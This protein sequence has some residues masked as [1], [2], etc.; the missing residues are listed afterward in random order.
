VHCG[1][2]GRDELLYPAPRLRPER[3]P[4]REPKGYTSYE[5]V[6]ALA[7]TGG[8]FTEIGRFSGI[9]DAVEA[10]TTGGDALV[11]LTDESLGEESS[12]RLIVGLTQFL[13]ISRRVVLAS[14]VNDAAPATV[15]ATGKWLA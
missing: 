13:Q 7:G 15:R 9:P 14:N 2:A 8:A 12:I 10:L 11:Q 3:L 4:L 1:R 5:S 6:V